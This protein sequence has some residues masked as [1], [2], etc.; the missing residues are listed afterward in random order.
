MPEMKSKATGAAALTL[1]IVLNPM[2]QKFDDSERGEVRRESAGA[3]REL[4]PFRRLFRWGRLALAAAVVVLAGAGRAEPT[5]AAPSGRTNAVPRFEV[6]AYDI[7]WDR[8][9]FTNAPVP[10][11][12]KYT[13]TN[14]GLDRIVAAAADVLGEY[15]KRGYAKANISIAEETITNGLVTM[16]VYLGAFPQVTLSGKPCFRSGE[17]G[18]GALLPWVVP[19]PR[20]ATA[21]APTNAAT[22]LCVEAYEIRGDTLL[23]TNTLMSIFAKRTGTNVTYADIM[24]AAQ[25]LQ[26]EYRTRGYPTV[27]VTVP[28][29]QRFTNG[30]PGIVKIRVFQGRLSEIYVTHNHYFSSNNVMRTLPSLHTNMILNGPLFQAEL[31]RANANQDRQIYP[32]LEPGAEENTTALQ[33]QVKDRLPLHGKIDLNNQS[34]PGTPDLRLNTSA[35]YQNL[36]QL[37][38]SMGVQYSFSPQEY[39]SGD[40][41]NFYDRPLVANYSAYYRLPLANPDSINEAVAARPENFGYDEASRKFRLPAATGRPELNFYGSRS[42]IDTGIQTLNSEVIYDVPGV[43]QVSREDVQQDLTLTE[44]LGA[45]LAAPLREFAG[46]R[47]SLSVGLDYKTYSLSSYKTNLFTFT[48]ITYREDGSPN[49]PVI[50]TV[51]SPVPA[52]QRNLDYLP[53]ALR[54]DGS[55]HDAR[56]TTGFG[57]GLSVNSWHSGSAQ[58]LESLA[59]STAASG[60]WV[61][62]TPSLWRNFMFWTNWTTSLRLD[63]QWASTPLISNE[64]Y[65]LGG[66]NTVRG[67]REGQVFGDTGWHV[68]LEQ[69]TPPQVVGMVYR[70]HPLTVR[71][72]LYMDYGEAYLLEPQGRPSRAP[73]WGTGFGVVASIGATWEARLL[74]SWP[75]L[76]LGDSRAGQPRFDFGLSAQF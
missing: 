21:G 58:D 13:G 12:A 26:M 10:A 74:C 62:L 42:T 66:V 19:E 40:Q 24:Q 45:R 76:N 61:I 4:G 73:L 8:Q 46:V 68:S 67:Y 37:E 7:K 63:G 18:L 17:S 64:Q 38:H 47:S 27:S 16:H 25:D 55:L 56:G 43:R 54:Y 57:L 31:D 65:G 69:A 33:L 59:G 71:G 36:W 50:S 23:S 39:K 53:L 3:Q 60:N 1:M 49:P 30:V 20:S 9:V 6:R 51:A 14:V 29:G 28:A 41:W 22:R 2:F 15:Q 48:E 5:A 52:T 34:S 11:L 70:N 44:N 72:T 75:L 35:S 32:Q